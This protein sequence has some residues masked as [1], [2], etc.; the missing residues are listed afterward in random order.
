MGSNSMRGAPRSQLT[1]FSTTQKMSPNK[2]F[3]RFQQQNQLEMSQREKHRKEQEN[4]Q[5]EAQQ[6]LEESIIEQE[7]AKQRRREVEGQVGDMS[8]LFSSAHLVSSSAKLRG[9]SVS[10]KEIEQ[11]YAK[12]GVEIEQYAPSNKMESFRN[13]QQQEITSKI[14]SDQVTQMQKPNRRASATM[15][16]RRQIERDIYGEQEDYGDDYSTRDSEM[17]IPRQSYADSDYDAQY[18]QQEQ[19]FSQPIDRKPTR[20]SQ[21]AASLQEEY[22]SKSTSFVELENEVELMRKALGMNPDSRQAEL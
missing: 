22:D 17:S 13:R 8:H 16:V 10:A 19:E 9:E 6:Q 20:R 4:K 12:Q 5:R 1:Q 18:A 14:R 2:T 7:M 11:K 3:T 21:A 15:R